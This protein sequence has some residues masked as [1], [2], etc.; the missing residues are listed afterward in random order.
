MISLNLEKYFENLKSSFH[1]FFLLS[2]NN[3]ILSLPS[4][5]S[6]YLVGNIWQF[7]MLL[8]V[9]IKTNLCQDI[10]IINMKKYFSKSRFHTKSVLSK[11]IIIQ[12]S[13]EIFKI[14]DILLMSVCRQSQCSNLILNMWNNF[15]FI[16]KY[17]SK[18]PWNFRNT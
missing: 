4:M 16:S 8:W 9:F 5:F 10:D 12:R 17:V 7:L 11:E 14:R 6:F 18:H 3:E 2:R 1:D 15:T 13:T